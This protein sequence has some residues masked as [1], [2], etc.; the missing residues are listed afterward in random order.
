VATIAYS[1]F[2]IFVGLFATYFCRALF[3]RDVFEQGSFAMEQEAYHNREA[4]S[5]FSRLDFGRALS[6]HFCRALLNTWRILTTQT[7][8]M[9]HLLDRDANQRA[10][11]CCRVL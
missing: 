2:S 1:R 3:N 7:Q 4:I 8:L 9:Q 11:V 10:A 6:T 5:I